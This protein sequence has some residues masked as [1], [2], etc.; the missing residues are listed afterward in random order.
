MAIESRLRELDHRH[1]DLD[2]AIASESRLPAADPTRLSALKRQ[3]LR[4]KEEIE[5]IRERL[6]PS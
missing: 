5:S 1:R 4:I 6:R 3:K 2:L